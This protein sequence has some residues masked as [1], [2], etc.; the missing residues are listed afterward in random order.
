MALTTD[1][2]GFQKTF[3]PR[4]RLTPKQEDEFNGPVY[5]VTD[6]DVVIACLGEKENLHEWVGAPLE[7]VKS[8]FENREVIVFEREEVDRVL[9]ESHQADHAYH[10]E[11]K[12]QSKAS[13]QLI[14]KTRFHSRTPKL[15]KGSNKLLKEIHPTE[16]RPHFL[17]EA[18]EGWWQRVLP[19][20][21]GFLVRLQDRNTG[22]LLPGEGFEDFLILI[23]KGKVESF[24][25]PELT[26]LGSA[27][28]R[29]AD[30]VVRYL[31]EK[32]MMPVVGLFIS[33]EDWAKWSHQS[34]PWP[35]VAQA[36]RKS[37]SV[38]VPFRVGLFS[39]ISARAYVG[40]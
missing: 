8:A 38:M 4:K 23:R 34:D 28:A 7:E 13:P 33:R 2:R 11:K 14:S 17:L 21:Y 9:V 39:L 19:D 24:F 16:F 40:V 22:A 1:W 12:V 29:E 26:S 32:V 30:Q 25:V 27:R 15:R 5:F 20:S 31:S 37:R 36:L 3:R 18:L 6:Q 35:E 10:E